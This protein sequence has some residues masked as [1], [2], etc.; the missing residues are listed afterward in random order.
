M[1][2]AQA[3][4]KWRE[5]GSPVPPPHLYKQLVVRD[6]AVRYGCSTLVETGTYQGEM[7]YAMVPHFDKIYSIELGDELYISAVAKFHR[8]PKVVLIHGDSGVEVAN[9]LPT[10][11]APAVFWLDGHW[12]MGITARGQK[13]TPIIEELSS[14]LAA[15]DI[16]HVILIDDARMFGSD[17]AYPSLDDVMRM[18]SVA[19][20]SARYELADDIIR[21]TPA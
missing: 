8:Q 5:S 2:P 6:Y 9:L 12:S 10:L 21:I 14:I 16:G 7:V 4:A 11:T 19:R 1:T 18:V 15:P 17:P 13:D 3:I 20:P